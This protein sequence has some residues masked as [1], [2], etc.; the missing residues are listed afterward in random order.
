MQ[1]VK[2]SLTEGFSSRWGFIFAAA[3]SAVG[4]GNIWKFPYI[5]GVNGG[6]AFVLVYIG[7]VLIIGLPLLVAEIA[8]GRMGREN[9]VDAL[10]NI[11]KAQ[12]ASKLWSL[13]GWFGVLAAFFVLSYYSVVAGWTLDYTVHSFSGHF[14]NQSS[15]QISDMFKNLLASPGQLLLYYTIIIAVTGFII[16]RGISKGIEKAV[17]IL[18]PVL[19]IILLALVFYAASTGYL[20]IGLKFLFHPNFSAINDQSILAAIG[21]AFFSLSLG[22]GTMITYGAYLPK[23]ASIGF[24]AVV[25]M[26]FDTV[27]ALLAGIAIFQ[28]CLPMA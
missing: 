21:H 4:L 18:F 10:L 14:A 9:P 19:L 12:N 7:A 23:K 15:A 2:S 24:T 3:G 20:A 17:Y 5:T 28:S 26:I 13:I 1:Q 11:A 8:V 22:I 6:G 16:A 25:V 27:I